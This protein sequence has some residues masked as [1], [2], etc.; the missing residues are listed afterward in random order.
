VTTAARLEAA[1]TRLEALTVAL[2][3]EAAWM[4]THG[5]IA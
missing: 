2:R 1:V 4:E 3:L 5:D